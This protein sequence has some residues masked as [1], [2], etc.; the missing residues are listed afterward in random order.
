MHDVWFAIGIQ[1]KDIEIFCPEKLSKMDCL[2]LRC[3]YEPGFIE[4][5]L[6]LGSGPTFT[7]HY[8]GKLADI[9]QRPH[10][11]TLIGLGGPASWIAWAYGDSLVQKFMMGPSLQV[12]FHEK[13]Y[14]DSKERKLVFKHCDELMPGELD[15]VFGHIHS[16]GSDH[17][18]WVFPIPEVLDELCD[19]LSGEW[20]EKLEFIFQEI[21]KELMG[22]NAQPRSW[23]DWRLFFHKSNCSVHAS[24]HHLTI[25]DF[26]DWR[27]AMV[28][29]DS[30]S[31]GTRCTSTISNTQNIYKLPQ[32]ESRE[33]L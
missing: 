22:C 27:S 8:L 21:Q 32:V 24:A 30:Q 31:I 13:G 19:H 17:D 25:Y 6:E 23:G 16:R 4:S 1:A 12:T 28:E 33:G 26:S 9:L 14:F 20:N 11:H 5:T 3:T 7:D 2:L 10:T 29:K 15:L 18:K